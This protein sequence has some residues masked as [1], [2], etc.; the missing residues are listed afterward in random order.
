MNISNASLPYPVLGNADDYIGNQPEAWLK[1]DPKSNDQ[2]HRIIYTLSFD[3]EN[4]TLISL[5]ELGEAALVIELDCP[6]TFQ[7]EVRPYS[8]KTVATWLKSGGAA[9]EL[10]LD[11]RNYAGT[12]SLTANITALKSFTLKN[13]GR[14]HQD[15]GKAEFP[16]SPGDVLAVFPGAEKIDLTLD[17]EHMYKN[18]GAAVKIVEDT[19][20]DAVVHT[21]L[22]D[23]YIEIHLPTKLYKEFKNIFEQHSLTAPAMLM[24][25]AQ[26]AVMKALVAIKENPQIRKTWA[27]AIRYRIDSEEDFKDY[28]PDEGIWDNDHLPDW[29]DKIDIIISLLFKEASENMIKSCREIV[30]LDKN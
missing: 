30:C 13:T 28:R 25:L 29:T 14:F 16:I 24:Y 15:Y 11:K 7:R 26:P 23:E 19:T 9:I 27:D 21:S 1:I 6:A 20:K 18:T 4:D 17:W 2:N 5:V 22:S 3:S 8:G 12:L 10:D